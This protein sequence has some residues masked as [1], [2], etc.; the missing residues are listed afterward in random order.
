MSDIKTEKAYILGVYC[1]DASIYS[2]K[3]KNR[4]TYQLNLKVQKRDDAFVYR[5]SRC[6][7]NVYGVK[8]RISYI[9]GDK[10][11]FKNSDIQDMVM[12]RVY[13]KKTVEDILSHVPPKERRKTYCWTVPDEIIQAEDEDVI[14]SFLQGFADSEGSVSILS[15]CV[16]FRSFNVNGLIQIRR[17]LRRMN[18]YSWIS[19]TLLVISGKP[20]LERFAEK[21]N[22]TIPRKHESLSNLLTSYKK[23]GYDASIYFEVLRLHDQGLGSRRISAKLSIPRRTVLNWLRGISTPCHAKQVIAGGESHG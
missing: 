22:F 9:K 7:F 18:I 10:G 3:T 14:T 15:K 21:V 17:L 16:S 5:F 8:G 19:K 11:S 4:S 13:S 6:I 20:N 1:G 2:K 12:Y 23:G